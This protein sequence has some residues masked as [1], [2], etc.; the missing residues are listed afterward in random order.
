MAKNVRKGAAPSLSG[1]VRARLGLCG[2][3]RLSLLER[4]LAICVGRVRRLRLVGLTLIRLSFGRLSL[5]GLTLLMGLS[6]VRLPLVGLTLVRLSLIGLT[7]LIG[8]SLVRLT[9]IRLSGSL[10]ILII[11]GRS[12]R[13][14]HSF[15][16]FALDVVF[17]IVEFTDTFS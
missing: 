15:L 9:L 7:L 8:L 14:F 6:L 17:C 3:K 11:G 12:G 13:L 2:R 10:V 4:F 16:D 5:V 1:P